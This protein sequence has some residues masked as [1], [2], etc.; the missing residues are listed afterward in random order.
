M[1]D[2][3]A[4]LYYIFVWPFRLLLGALVDELLVRLGLKRRVATGSPVWRRRCE[5]PVARTVR[6]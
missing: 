5:L 1:R 4:L 3:A 2:A 6:W